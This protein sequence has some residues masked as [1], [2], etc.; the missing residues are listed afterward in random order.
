MKINDLLRHS[1][2]ECRTK[3]SGEIKRKKIR[4]SL[5]KYLTKPHKLHEK[6]A[7]YNTK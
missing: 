3:V 2:L 4:Y 1:K 6:R 5:I 7:V